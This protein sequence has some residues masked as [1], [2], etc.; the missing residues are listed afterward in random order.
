MASPARVI[1]RFGLLIAACAAIGA[2]LKA[3]TPVFTERGSL[4]SDT[5]YALIEWTAAGSVSLEIAPENDHS[6]VRT[7]YSGANS[8]YFV[9]GL[10]D[11]AYSLRLRGEGGEVSAPLSLAVSHQSLTRALMLTALGAL[12]FILTVGAI[13]RG[14]R[15]E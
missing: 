11:G 6:E 3:D 5:G 15:D 8:A 13:V 4:S 12:V 9:S 1:R 10:A 2:P 14:A 7:L